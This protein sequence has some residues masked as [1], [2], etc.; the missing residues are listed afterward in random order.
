MSDSRVVCVFSVRT[1]IRRCRNNFRHA[2]NPWRPAVAEVRAKKATV[3]TLCAIAKCIAKLSLGTMK[4]RCRINAAGGGGGN[5]R[6]CRPHEHKS[7]KMPARARGSSRG[8]SPSRSARRVLGLDGFAR[9]EQRADQ[10]LQARTCPSSLAGRAPASI[11]ANADRGTPTTQPTVVACLQG[12]I[13]IKTS[14]RLSR[15]RTSPQTSRNE[16]VC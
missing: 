5:V 15:P 12:G 1:I 9:P 4:S 16:C 6:R 8:R 7:L 11:R 2:A 10:G 14:F 3:G 13:A